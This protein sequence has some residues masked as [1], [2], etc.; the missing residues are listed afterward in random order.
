MP[1][2]PYNHGGRRGKW[3]GGNENGIEQYLNILTFSPVDFQRP[4]KLVA[5]MMS[6]CVCVCLCDELSRTN[7]E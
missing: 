1:L 7:I 2:L 4:V 5:C 6:L 3:L